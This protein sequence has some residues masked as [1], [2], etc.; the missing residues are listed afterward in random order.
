MPLDNIKCETSMLTGEEVKFLTNVIIKDRRI[1]E[2]L[3]M[4]EK[5]MRMTLARLLANAVSEVGQFKSTNIDQTKYMEWV[6]KYQ[7]CNRYLISTCE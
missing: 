6:D 2:W 4:V 5:E 1:N 3:T 7:V